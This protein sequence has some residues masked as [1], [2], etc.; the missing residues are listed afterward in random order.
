M[1]KVWLDDEFEARKDGFVG[2]THT[3]WPQETI[4]I[5]KQ[6]NVEV[7][8]LD[9]DLG[10]DFGY[11][12]PRT[13]YDVLKWIEEQVYLHAFVPPRIHLHT[14]NSS[15][16]DKMKLAVRQIM[17]QHQKNLSQIAESA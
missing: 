4:E 8:S 9:H 2:W 15:A 17:L 6:G 5:L 3:R 11:T 16:R 1:M 12:N 14:R 7:L 13:G 10:E